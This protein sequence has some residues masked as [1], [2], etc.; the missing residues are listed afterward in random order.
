[1]CGKNTCVY[2]K[3]HLQQRGTDRI[4]YRVSPRYCAG[5]KQNY[6]VIRCGEEVSE[7]NNLIAHRFRSCQI[8]AVVLENLPSDAE[9]R[10]AAISRS[11]INVNIFTVLRSGI[12]FAR[13][14]RRE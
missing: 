12:K 2:S 9:I 5:L 3:A 6:K 13:E 4:L 11:N 1:M 10:L 14:L 7:F 8:I